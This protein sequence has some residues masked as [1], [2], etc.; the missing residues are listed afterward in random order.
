MSSPQPPVPVAASGGVLGALDGAKI[1]T[2]VSRSG[3]GVFGGIA[4]LPARRRPA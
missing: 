1:T 4:H 2:P 3:C